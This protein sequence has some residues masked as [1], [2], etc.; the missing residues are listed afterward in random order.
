[1]PR[2]FDLEITWV[3]KAT[4]RIVR[5]AARRKDGE[6][7][8]P[9]AGQFYIMHFEHDEKRTSRSYSIA[10]PVDGPSDSIELCIALVPN[11]IGSQIVSQWDVGSLFRATG[12]HGR[13]FLREEERDLVLIATGTG[14][15]PFHSM[16]HEIV[17]R[18]EEGAS[19]DVVHGVYTPDECLYAESFE[20]LEQKYATFCYHRCVSDV[21]VEAPYTRGWVQ[22]VL[23]SSP[24]LLTRT[25][26]I[27]GN[28]D[29]VEAVKT[30]LLEQGVDR[31]L[32]RTEAYT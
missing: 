26:L 16:Y 25:A 14:I 18:L 27:C 29:M 19:V 3:C 8:A 21:D 15:A 4:D 2:Y 31:S 20:A 10:H 7:L 22:A 11:G 12:P 24:Q 9:K 28:P 5:C 30:W 23:E 6:L 17:E 13:F 32:V 1:M